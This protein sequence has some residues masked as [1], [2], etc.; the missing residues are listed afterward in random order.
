MTANVAAVRLALDGGADLADKVNPRLVSLT[1]SEKRGEE[2]DELNL[3]LHNHDG[4]LEAPEPGRALL[5]QVGWLRGADVLPGMVDK[6]RF[7]VD[8]VT[9]TGPPDTITI[10]ARG[11]DLTGTYRKR[12][13]E[14]WKNTTLGS[15]LGRIADRNGG[16]ARVESRLAATPIAAIE[17]EGKSDM[18]FVRDLGRR[19]DAVATWKGGVLLFLPIGASASASGTPLPG[20]VLRKRDGWTWTF[21]RAERDNFDGAEAQWHD[22]DAAKRKTV[23]TG[24]Q[25]RK[26]LKRV[27]A[28]EAEA[29]QAAQSSAKRAARDPFKFEYELA[30]ADPEIQPDQRVTLRGWNARIDGIKWLVESVETSFD[31]SGLRQ[32]LALESA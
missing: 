32:K 5:L 30:I 25:N 20:L 1:L 19:F 11:A 16:F 17:Q 14:V 12:R 23:S 2:A 8:E 22:Q 26:K 21:T 27:Y 4:L 15:I 29:R 28:T 13:S 9:E 6:G 7:V 10:R 18:A 3:T 31:A 24:G